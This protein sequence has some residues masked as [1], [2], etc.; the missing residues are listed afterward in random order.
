M[1]GGS[2][3]IGV[4][5]KTRESAVS[6]T[7]RVAAFLDLPRDSGAGASVSS[8]DEVDWETDG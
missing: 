1:R 3:I 5:L 8:F 4:A 7:A 6:P 2:T